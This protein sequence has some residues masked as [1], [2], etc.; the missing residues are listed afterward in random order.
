MALG[1]SSEIL[2]SEAFGEAVAYK[3]LSLLL[4]FFW[5]CFN[6]ISNFFYFVYS[7]SET[8]QRLS[9]SFSRYVKK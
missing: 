6:I 8:P 3:L 1:L 4:L 5:I 7:F 9:T 2:K